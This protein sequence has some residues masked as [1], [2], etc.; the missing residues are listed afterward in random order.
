MSV[1]SLEINSPSITIVFMFCGRQKL[2]W[3]ENNMPISM[4]DLGK[5]EST[6]SNVL[7]ITCFYD[8]GEFY[9]SV[10]LGIDL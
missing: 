2:P 7:Y 3:A 9:L 10:F 1:Y 4:T 6:F 8:K 5:L